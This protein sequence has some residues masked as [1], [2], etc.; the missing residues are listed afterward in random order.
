[1]DCGSCAFS[2]EVRTGAGC[3]LLVGAKVREPVGATGT[4]QGAALPKSTVGQEAAWLRGE[5]PGAG[6]TRI[7]RG[8]RFSCFL[9]PATGWAGE[10]CPS[11]VAFS[12][13]RRVGV[14]LQS[15]GSLF[16]Q[17]QRSTAVTSASPALQTSREGVI[18]RA[19][20]GLR[21]CWGDPSAV[22]VTRVTPRAALP[23]QSSAKR[24]ERAG[25]GACV[26]VWKGR[27]ERGETARLPVT[28]GLT[29]VL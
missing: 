22:G 26:L 3:L 23:G 14:A 18:H 28:H 21:S 20:R 16:L 25:L 11:K 13:A 1:M 19:Q 10:G 5:V 15:W 7:A 9:H 2:W 27:C 6:K 12:R 29:G 24:V 4:G 17:P 8:V